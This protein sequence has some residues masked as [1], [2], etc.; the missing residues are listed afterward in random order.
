MPS[1]VATF[2]APVKRGDELIIRDA[3][4]QVELVQDRTGFGVRHLVRGIDPVGHWLAVGADADAVPDRQ[5]EEDILVPFTH[6]GSVCPALAAQARTT[7]LVDIPPFLLSLGIK[8]EHF[9]GGLQPGALDHG[10]AVE[11]F[12]GDARN[13]FGKTAGGG[14]VW[15][16]NVAPCVMIHDGVCV[17]AESE[18]KDAEYPFHGF[19]SLLLL[20]RAK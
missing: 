17:G 7:Y 11:G 4:I 15:E 10:L 2:I 20:L 9:P 3:N 5:R 19:S 6:Q 18:Q 1:C 12:L 8:D 14:L 16:G 13:S